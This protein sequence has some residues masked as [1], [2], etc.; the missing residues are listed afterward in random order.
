MT[1]SET[2][3]EAAAQRVYEDKGDRKGIVYVGWNNEPDDVKERWRKDVRV[4]VK[5]YLTAALSEQVVVPSVLLEI[6]AERKRQIEVE[7]YDAKHDDEHSHGEIA[8]AAA[9]YAYLAGAESDWDRQEQKKEWWGP[10]H[11]WLRQMWPW[12]WFYF[13]PKGR[14]NELICS[15]ALSLAEIERIDRAMIAAAPPP[16][17]PA[18]ESQGG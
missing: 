2:A 18:G 13:K 5:A 9:C 11:S 16:V 14:R 1:L 3:I 17:F 15:A 4:S 8:R 7:G 6:A 12:E 10:R